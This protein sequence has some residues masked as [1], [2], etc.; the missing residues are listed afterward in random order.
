MH[1]QVNP[2]YSCP[3]CGYLTMPCEPPGTYY[4]CP[5]CFWEDDSS[6]FHDPHGLHRPNYTSLVEGRRNF[7]AFGA[8]DPDA[9]G[10]VRPPHPHEVPEG[11]RRYG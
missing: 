7:A 10:S 5:V 8:C 6:G 9:L 1:E 11:G 4:I 2:T 3:C